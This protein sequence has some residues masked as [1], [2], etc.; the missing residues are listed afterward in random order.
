M[1]VFVHQN[2]ILIV[3]YILETYIIM[4]ILLIKVISLLFQLYEMMGK[5][6]FNYDNEEVTIRYGNEVSFIWFIFLHTINTSICHPMII[7]FNYRFNRLRRIYED[8]VSSY[9]R[10]FYQLVISN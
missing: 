4:N 9:A 6:V 3:I 5:Q 8:E 10:R 2:V 1:T 7:I